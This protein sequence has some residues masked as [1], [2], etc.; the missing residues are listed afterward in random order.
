MYEQ[1]IQDEFIQLMCERAGLMIK[2]HQIYELEQTIKT[3]CQQFSINPDVLFERLSHCTEQDP[4]FEYFIAGVTVGESYFFR[5]QEQFDLLENQLLPE[6]VAEKS[7][8]AMPSIRIWSAGCST[9]EEIFSIAMLINEMGLQKKGIK[10]QLLATDIN[11]RSLITA[12]NGVYS[13]WSMRAIPKLYLNKYFTKQDGC[14]RLNETIRDVVTFSY[15]NL[16][17]ESYP[18]IMNGTCAQDIILCRNVFIYFVPD[19]IKF[20]AEQL[21]IALAAGGSLLFGASDPVNCYMSALTH[22]R[23]LDR[24]YYKKPPTLLPEEVNAPQIINIPEIFEITSSDTAEQQIVSLVDIEDNAAELM[25]N[26]HW[27][28]MLEYLHQME[29]IQPLSYSLEIMKIK[30]LAN[31]GFA[32]NAR[33]QCQT[34]INSY[35]LA[36][37]LYYLLGLCQSESEQIA[38]AETSFRKA[39][40]LDSNRCAH[41]IRLFIIA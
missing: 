29:K 35:P 9:G 2:N 13:E 7:K 18:S 11:T 40:Y 4:I 20:I 31:L 10:F 33:Q 26:Y 28:E 6:L 5:D 34:L 32:E 15:L 27:Q 1:Q 8:L 24:T 21:S 12:L 41:S 25:K 23:Y 37:E 22:C 16:N 14:Y 3:C 17:S 30:A 38:E 19:R 39:L 36:S